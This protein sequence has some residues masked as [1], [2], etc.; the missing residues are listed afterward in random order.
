MSRVLFLEH[1]FDKELAAVERE[2][3]LVGALT[4]GEIANTGDA[5]LEFYNKTSVVGILHDRHE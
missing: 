2:M 5:Y 4:L 3:P 1:N